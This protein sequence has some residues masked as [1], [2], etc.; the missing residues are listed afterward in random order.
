MF[1]PLHDS[2]P[3]RYLKAPTATYGLIATMVL[4][5]AATSLDFP[6]ESDI[7]FAGARHGAGAAVW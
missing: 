7:V 6:V 5:Y 3:L 1:L 4:I 2:V